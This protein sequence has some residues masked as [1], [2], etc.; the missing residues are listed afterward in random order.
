MNSELFSEK[1]E[2]EWGSEGFLGKL[3]R[4]EF[5]PVAAD[6]FLN[7]L[8]KSKLQEE[9]VYPRRLV[10]LLWYLPS[11]LDWQKERVV[12]MGGSLRD[13]EYFITAVHNQLENI[14]GVP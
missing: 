6:A 12:K 11:F 13:Y 3:R 7:L 10:S 9:A 2:N 1:L 14:L 4:G 8:Q 5:S